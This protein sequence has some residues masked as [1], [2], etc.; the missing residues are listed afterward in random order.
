[1]QVPLLMKT[2]PLPAAITEAEQAHWSRHIQ[3]SICTRP[4]ELSRYLRLSETGLVSVGW[5]SQVVNARLETTGQYLLG[6]QFSFADLM[7]AHILL[8][9]SRAKGC[10]VKRFTPHAMRW[11]LFIG[12]VCKCLCALSCARVL[13]LSPVILAY[14]KV[15][16][17]LVSYF[18]DHALPC[19]HSVLTS[20]AAAA[21]AAADSA[22]QKSGRRLSRLRIFP[23]PTTAAKNEER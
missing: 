23:T 10:A 16:L 6:Q 15:R 17:A 8:W 9:A 4:T 3:V 14:L 22:A 11:T 13:E 12:P 7:L 19:L 5:Y 2:T 18:L 21:T 1:M 20:T